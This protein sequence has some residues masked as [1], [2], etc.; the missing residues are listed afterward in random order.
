LG[1]ILGKTN[2]K[3]DILSRKDQ[4]DTKENNK[5]VQLLKKELWKRRT[6]AKI[7]MLKQSS[8][9]EETDLIKEIQRNG[10]KEKEIIQELQKEDRQAWKINRIVD[11]NEQIYIPNNKKLQEQILQ[12]YHNALNV[13]H[14]ELKRMLQL[15][16]QSCWWP[17][18][19]EDI[20]SYIQECFK[21]QQNK[22]QHQKKVGELYPLVIP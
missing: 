17:G 5:D 4:V 22:V 6:I 7:T 10:I 13:G 15:I 11:I 20:K 19:K 2:T 18:I 16:K 3:T 14:S 12:K 8:V 9:Q 21:C 1:Y